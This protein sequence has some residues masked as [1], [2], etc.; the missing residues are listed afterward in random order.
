MRKQKIKYVSVKLPACGNAYPLDKLGCRKLPDYSPDYLKKHGRK[1]FEILLNE[2]P[3]T[4]YS[5]LVRCIKQKEK[6]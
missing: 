2:V 4:V 6:L 1:L 3:S 5:E